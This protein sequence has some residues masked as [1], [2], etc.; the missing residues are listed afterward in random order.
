[1]GFSL[2]LLIGK[3]VNKI[4]KRL[5]STPSFRMGTP[6]AVI[7]VR[8]TRFSVEVTKKQRTEVE[9]FED[10][11]EVEGIGTVDLHQA[12][13]H[14]HLGALLFGYL[15]RK[16]RAT[17]RDHCGRSAHS[18]RRRTAEA[19]LNFV[20]H[21]ADQQFEGES[22]VLIG[23]LQHHLAVGFHQHLVAVRKTQQE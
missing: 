20:D 19:L 12:L 14:L 13:E 6:T 1:K 15:N 11:V 18:E 21:L 23:G 2:E 5:G 16:P 3:V 17:N 8:G 10:L 22:L 7:T 4:E 9:V